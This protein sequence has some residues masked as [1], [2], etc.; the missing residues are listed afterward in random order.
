MKDPSAKKSMYLSF[1][2]QVDDGNG[3]TRTIN[4]DSEVLDDNYYFSTPAK[5][6]TSNP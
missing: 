2:V 6:I 1:S 5:A 3:G 4:A